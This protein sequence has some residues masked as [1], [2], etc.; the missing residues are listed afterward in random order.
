MN[1]FIR[2]L[3]VPD[4][5]DSL[6][7]LRRARPA[8]GEEITLEFGLETLEVLCRAVLDRP[9]LDV[10]SDFRATGAL[11]YLD[12]PPD[13]RT[14]EGVQLFRLRAEF[15][16]RLAAADGPRTAALLAA[17]RA[18]LQPLRGWPP[19]DALLSDPSSLASALAPLQDATR[20]AAAAG[21]SLCL[22]ILFR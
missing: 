20:R 3:P 16:R 11:E 10:G 17:W 19:I 12:G 6:E 13:P 18:G 21:R 15:V 2:L 22:T 7:T 8:A 9:P 14:D 4:E 5:V 1:D